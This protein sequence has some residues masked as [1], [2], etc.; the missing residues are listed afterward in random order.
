MLLSPMQELPSSLP[1]NYQLPAGLT[2][3]QHLNIKEVCG[4]PAQLKRL[5]QQQSHLVD[6]LAE[7]HNFNRQFPAMAELTCRDVALVADQLLGFA[8][9]W[10]SRTLKPSA[11]GLHLFIQAPL[12]LEVRACCDID[13]EASSVR[14]ASFWLCIGAW[15]T[16]QQCLSLPF[17]V[18]FVAAKKALGVKRHTIKKCM[19]AWEKVLHYLR[20]QKAVDEVKVEVGNELRHAA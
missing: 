3:S 10:A 14:S 15:I 8:C 12:V 6:W 17:P 11:L 18:Q 16:T 4:S 20:A 1:R 7:A 13:V 19:A 9:Q 5:Q 2:R